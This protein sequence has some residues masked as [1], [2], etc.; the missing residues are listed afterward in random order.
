MVD[1]PVGPTS[2]TVVRQIRRAAGVRRVGHGG[3]LDPLASGVLPVCLG[4]ATK[5]APFLLDADKEYE[6]T[7]RLGVE[8]DTDDAAGTPTATRDASAVGE[9]AVR[10]ALDRFRGDITQVPPAFAAIKRDGRPLYDYARAGTP[11][12]AAPRAVTIHALELVGFGGPGD[13][14][15]RVH[16]SKGTYVRALARD[17]GR[18]LEVGAHVT[19]LRR[20]RSGPFSLAEARPLAA[21]LD[22]LAGAGAPVPLVSLTAAL[23]HLPQVPVAEAVARALRAGQRVGW[24][25]ATGGSAAARVCLVDPAG[26]LVAV[27]A[28]RP[29]GLVRTLRVFLVPGSAPT[30]KNPAAPANLR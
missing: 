6:V 17:L 15:L 7:V 5:L 21:I 16:C 10:A 25:E 14:R 29:D 27:A 13:V 19:A 22:A 3:T 18:A 12:E 1:K 30:A 2:F 4:E 11:I 24:A 26:E 23:R 20:T 8:T 28:P 9:A